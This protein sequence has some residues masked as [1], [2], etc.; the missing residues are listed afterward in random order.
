MVYLIPIIL[1]GALIRFYGLTDQSL[2]MDEIYIAQ[3]IQDFSYQK[4]EHVW[5]SENHPPLYI[6]FLK[7]WT[8][9][10]GETEWSLRAFSAF[11]GTITLPI[12]YKLFS[13]LSTRKIALI[14]TALFAISLLAV[15]YSQEVR[16]FSLWIPLSALSFYFFFLWLRGEKN[17]YLPWC[18]ATILALFTHIYSVFILFIQIVLYFRERHKTQ[19]P[20]EFG[21]SLTAIFACSS[22]LLWWV[23]LHLG[24]STGFVHPFSFLHYIYLPFAYT[25]GFSFGPSVR[26]LHVITTQE[27]LQRN[28]WSV[29]T[30]IGI[31]LMVLFAAIPQIWRDRKNRDLF[32]LV[33]FCLGI[34]VVTPF[35]SKISFKVRS[36]LFLSPFFYLYMGIGVQRLMRDRFLKMIPLVLVFFMLFSL[37]QYF[38]NPIYARDDLRRTVQIIKEKPE[39]PV[40]TTPICTREYLDF[41]QLDPN[42]IVKEFSPTTIKEFKDYPYLFLIWN[43]TWT[44]YNEKNYKKYFKTHYKIISEYDLSGVKLQLVKHND[45]PSI[46]LKLEE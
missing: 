39:V 42:Q 22:V 44:L 11:L 7:G 2:W 46:L 8:I 27:L 30:T 45:N 20:I 33:L 28:W 37:F 43:R 23:W 26:E 32:L 5:Y 29:G 18:L 38:T 21:I 35:F 19:H 15:Y 17:T 41:Y 14:G 24:E 1:V 25:L 16:Y 4:I 40:L 9:L 3:I 34:I 6:L 10:W 36:A 31:I 12:F 13:L